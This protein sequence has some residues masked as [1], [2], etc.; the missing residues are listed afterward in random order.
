IRGYASD[1]GIYEVDRF[2]DNAVMSGIS[3][4]TIIHGKGT[5]VLKNAIR[6]HVK[7]H[8]QVKSSR[9]GMFGEGEDGVTVCELK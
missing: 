6:A 3:V 7:K 5:G 9:R 4:V 8:P 2:I 1:E